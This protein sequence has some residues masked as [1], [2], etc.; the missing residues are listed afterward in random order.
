M[1]KDLGRAFGEE[2]EEDFAPFRNFLRELLAAIP[3]PPVPGL[4]SL[5]AMR[6]I[7]LP[8]PA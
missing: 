6:A 2:A 1:V 3:R 5:A 4:V 8:P 7:L